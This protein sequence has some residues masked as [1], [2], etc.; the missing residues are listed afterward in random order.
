MERHGS[1][2]AAAIRELQ[3]RDHALQNLYMIMKWTA[4]VV[5]LT[6]ILP[7]GG[8]LQRISSTGH[9]TSK[10]SRGSPCCQRQCL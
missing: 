1:A 9:G 5:L 2:T 4:A 7:P 10:H 8:Q 3:V 6:Y